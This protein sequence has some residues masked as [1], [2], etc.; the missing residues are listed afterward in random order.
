MKIIPENSIDAIV[1][2][3]PYG[4]S[5]MGKDWDNF[6]TNLQRYQEW[7]RQWASECVRILKPGGHLLAFGGSRTYHRMTCGIEDA[8][9]EIRDCIMW[10]YSTG[11]PKSLNISKAIDKLKGIGG[12]GN[13]VSSEAKKWDGW[14]TA[15]KPAYEPIVVARKPISEK[16]V[17]MNVLKYGTGGINI[18]ECRIGLT[19]GVRKINIKSNSGGFAGEGFGCDRDLEQINKGRFPANVIFE[20]T[21]D[22]MIGENHTNP[23]CPCYMLDKQSGYLHGIGNK[24]PVKKR[25]YN[26]SSYKVGVFEHNPDYHHNT[27]GGASRFFYCAKACRSER[28]IGLWHLNPKK[29]NDGRSTPVDNP[30]QQG[31][32][33]RYNTHP[34]VKPIKL[35]QYLIKL[36]TKPKGIVLDPFAG[37]GTTGIACKNLGVKFIGIEKSEEYCKIAKER[38]AQGVLF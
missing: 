11:F 25:D 5:F 28:E 21:C 16:N 10:I 20:C 12:Q 23:E 22:E 36:V 27:G 7:T 19:G 26:A 15:L 24:K 30:F 18:D 3:P 38:L 9:F 4:L 37:S 32:T 2:D 14:G 33:Q 1:T 34:T 13:L 8:G 35:M 6:G 17:A 31:E 29:V